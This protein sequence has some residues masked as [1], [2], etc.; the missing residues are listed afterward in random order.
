MRKVALN[1]NQ[2]SGKINKVLDYF[3]MNSYEALFLLL[4]TAAAESDFGT[5]LHQDVPNYSPDRHAIGF[6]QMEKSTHHDIWL[7]FLMYNEKLMMKIIK[8]FGIL[9]TP[10]P[11]GSKLENTHRV[12]SLLETDIDYQILMARLHYRRD[13]EPLPKNKEDI[14]RY[15]KRV[16]NT[17]AGKGTVEKFLKKYKKYVGE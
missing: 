17:A 3:E 12:D 10:I 6:F 2:F 14:A 16:Y 11:Q 8:Y 7:N 5:Y 4:G 1:K 15:W 9:E 13:R